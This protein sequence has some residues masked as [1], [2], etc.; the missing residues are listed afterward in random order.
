MPEN[1]KDTLFYRD[2]IYAIKQIAEFEVER[3]EEIES[4]INERERDIAVEHN[5]TIVYKP[6][7]FNVELFGIIMQIIARRVGIGANY[8]CFPSEIAKYPE[9]VTE[10]IDEL[11]AKINSLNCQT[12]KS[13]GLTF[14]KK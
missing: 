1:E 12:E 13:V 10:A 9:L 3:N 5:G 8:N 4:R 14:V 7:D 11:E 2:L 6:S